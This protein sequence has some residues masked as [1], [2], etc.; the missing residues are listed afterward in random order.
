MSMR[1]KSVVRCWARGAGSAALVALVIG[2]GGCLGGKDVSVL[3]VDLS[4][5]DIAP[6]AS[7]T[8][9][10]PLTAE[11]PSGT[12][13][14]LSGARF[15]I[16]NP[17]V[18]P[19]VDT[20]VSGDSDVLNVPLPPS[21]FAFDYTITLQDGWALVET[22]PDG[23]EHPVA[24]NLDGTAFQSFTIR[25]DRVTPINYQF[26]ASGTRVATGTGSVSVRVAVDDTTIDDFEDGDGNLIA[27]ARRNGSWFTFNDGTGVE[28]PAPGS[29]VLPEVLD[30]N[31]TFVLHATGRDFSP[32][33]TLPDGS[34]AF[35]AGVA[36]ELHLDPESQVALPYDGSGYGGLQ[37]D[38]TLRFPATT[39]IRLSFLVATSATTPVA[40]G[41]TCTTGCSDDFGLF[42]TFN[43]S[44]VSF[45]TNITWDQLTQQGFGTPVAFDPKTILSLKWLLAFPDGGQGASADDF[46][47]QLDNVAFLPPVSNPAAAG[48]PSAAEP[49]AASSAPEAPAAPGASW[50]EPR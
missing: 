6:V 16:S 17:F 7:G 33:V 24:A 40:E 30:A 23:S 3:D 47:F 31:A 34:F 26:V 29:P 38:F 42:G 37:F 25:S 48:Q 49:P 12:A 39:R 1:V 28:T 13:Y 15:A 46:D 14:R 22:D 10:L 4:P 36:V 32:A 11:A 45:S 50:T 18:N 19:P 8:L 41:G 2:S 20:V 44:P 43:I 5:G 9:Q 21:A 35:G 27:L